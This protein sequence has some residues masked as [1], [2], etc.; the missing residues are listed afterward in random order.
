[1]GKGKGGG[2]QQ[3]QYVAAVPLQQQA[4]VAAQP[5]YVAAQPQ[6]VVAAQPQVQVRSQTS[7]WCMG[8][9]LCSSCNLP[10]EPAMH[11]HQQSVPWL[12]QNCCSNSE[13]TCN[14]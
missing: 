7:A 5:Q 1:M 10:N 11:A 13:H 2:V 4:Y 14:Q 6:Y 9:Q 8:C 12:L 3:Q